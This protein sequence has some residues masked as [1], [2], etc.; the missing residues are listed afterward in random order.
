MPISR[1]SLHLPN[2]DGQQI[3][4]QRELQKSAKRASKVFTPLGWAQKGWR[5]KRRENLPRF[6]SSS[7][8][9]VGV[10][11]VL[12]V[13]ALFFE[14]S[15]VPLIWLAKPTW[16]LPGLFGIPKAEHRA[17][18]L[19]LPSLSLSLSIPTLVPSDGAK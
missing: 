3:F 14:N 15:Q 8:L 16:S 18:T 5:N 6:F 2:A 19:H 4:G 11:G 9:G 13:V 1:F 7:Q 17:S 10:G 12:S